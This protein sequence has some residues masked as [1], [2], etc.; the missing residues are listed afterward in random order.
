[1]GFSASGCVS[2][3]QRRAIEVGEDAISPPRDFCVQKNSIGEWYWT[4]RGANSKVVAVSEGYR[5]KSDCER[6]IEIVRLANENTPIN[7]DCPPPG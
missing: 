3:S 2:A 4:L 7:Y 1:M 6:A 5:R